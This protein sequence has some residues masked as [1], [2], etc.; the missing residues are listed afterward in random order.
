MA[1]VRKPLPISGDGRGRRGRASYAGFMRGLLDGS[2]SATELHDTTAP[3]GTARVVRHDVVADPR[4]PLDSFDD[5]GRPIRARLA[6]GVFEVPSRRV[7]AL[8]Y[9]DP[10]GEGG[11]PPRPTSPDD[12]PTPER[13]RRG[14]NP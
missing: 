3:A 11:G 13:P 5:E 4:G 7:V 6:R 2:T 8:Q 12:R 14:Q 9:T 1:S 10:R